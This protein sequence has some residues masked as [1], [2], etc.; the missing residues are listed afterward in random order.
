MGKEQITKTL[1]HFIIILY[2]SIEYNKNNEANDTV[3]NEAAFS[4]QDF[5]YMVQ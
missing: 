4:L 3:L 5:Y 2:G 1:L